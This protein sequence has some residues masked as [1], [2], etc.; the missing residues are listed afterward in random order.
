M[1]RTMRLS[2]QLRASQMTTDEEEDEETLERASESASLDLDDAQPDGT[3]VL[4][5]Q[6]VTISDTKKAGIVSVN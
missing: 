2:S 5:C 3:P 4:F 6:S 1:R